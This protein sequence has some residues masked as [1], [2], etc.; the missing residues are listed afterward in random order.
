VLEFLRDVGGLGIVLMY[1]FEYVF[2]Q[3]F[4]RTKINAIIANKGYFDPDMP[5][6]SKESF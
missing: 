6:N 3:L 5:K 4:A 2:S 1:F